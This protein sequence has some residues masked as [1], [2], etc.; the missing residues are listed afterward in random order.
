N[1]AKQFGPF[2][3]NVNA[4][5]PGVIKTAMTE[6]LSYDMTALALRRFGEQAEVGD[7]VAF[8][9]SDESSYLTGTTIDING[10]LYMR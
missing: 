7:L 9:A 5:S 4:L 2:N 8:L 1:M 10:G 6:K 3:I